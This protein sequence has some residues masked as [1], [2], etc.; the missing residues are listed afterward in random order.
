MSLASLSRRYDVIKERLGLSLNRVY[1]H[2]NNHRG[3]ALLARSHQM[4][5]A[6]HFSLIS[7]VQYSYRE[8]CNINCFFSWICKICNQRWVNAWASCDHSCSVRTC[9]S[10]Y[11]IFK[12]V[13]CASWPQIYINCND[14]HS[15]VP[16]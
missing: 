15:S 13:L 9:T 5:T 12:C 11:P 7:S 3:Q 2:T 4:T 10:I 1:I 6:A 14:L 8:S 16:P